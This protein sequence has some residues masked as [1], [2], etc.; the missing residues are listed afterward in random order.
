[1]SSRAD[2]RRDDHT[3]GSSVVSGASRQIALRQN[4]GVTTL[5]VVFL[6][7]HPPERLPEVARAADAAGLDELW[8]WED[9]FYA[10]GLASLSTALAVTND[11]GSGWVCYRRR[12][13]TWR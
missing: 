12:C 11:C 3:P 13:A 1:M 8:L 9:C 6:P 7:Y 10:S 5:G 4:D 2:A